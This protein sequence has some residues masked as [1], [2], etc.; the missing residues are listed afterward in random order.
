MLFVSTFVVFVVALSA[1]K[2]GLG[3]DHVLDHKSER[4]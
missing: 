2:F 1:F 4:T 3:V